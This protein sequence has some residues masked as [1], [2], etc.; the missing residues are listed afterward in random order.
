MY[1]M[2]NCGKSPN[3][4][5]CTFIYSIFLFYMIMLF[6][7]F[8][9]KIDIFFRSILIILACFLGF[10]KCYIPSFSLK[11]V[12]MVYMYLYF[13]VFSRFSFSFIRFLHSRR[14]NI[15]VKKSFWSFYI[16]SVMCLFFFMMKLLYIFS[17][18]SF[19]ERLHI[20]F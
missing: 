13:L 4:C 8:E 6:F 17:S 2:N 10:Y 19:C 9:L 14:C 12:V 16:I 20:L 15:S 1:V 5:P 11:V 7:I 3:S 18:F